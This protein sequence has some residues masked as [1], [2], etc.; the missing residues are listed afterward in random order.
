MGYSKLEVQGYI[1]S[2]AKQAILVPANINK[3]SIMAIL[4]IK[5][6]SMTSYLQV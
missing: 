3:A 5:S 6:C 1:S 4:E 2:V